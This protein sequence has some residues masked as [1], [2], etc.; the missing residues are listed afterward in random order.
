MIIT[1]GTKQTCVTEAS[2]ALNDLF[3][4][5]KSRGFL[6]LVSGGSSLSLLEYLNPSYFGPHSTVCVLDE[7]YSDDP[8][9]SN[10]QQLE[11][12]PFF[13]T[14]KRNGAHFIDTKSNPHESIHSVSDRF[15]HELRTWVADIN[16]TIIASVGIG[17]DAHTSGIIPYPDDHLFFDAT[18]NNNNRWVSSY[19]AGHRNKFRHRIT[20]TIPFLRLINHAIIYIQGEDKRYALNKVLSAEGT[21][22]ESPGRIWREIQKA[23]IYTDISGIKYT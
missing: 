14:A 5:Q 6:F 1:T 3:I 19:D 9:V 21:L 15:E 7:R 17:Q 20:T 12:T 8:S 4:K 22:Y 13:T 2:N 18:F 10:M 11:I 23:H 16:G